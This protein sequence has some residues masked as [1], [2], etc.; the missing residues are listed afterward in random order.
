MKKSPSGSPEQRL[1]KLAMDLLVARK[2]Q[3]IKTGQTR[4]TIN[5]TNNLS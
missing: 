3:N 1:I 5:P 2:H 4:L